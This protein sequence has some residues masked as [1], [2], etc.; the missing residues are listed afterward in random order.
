MSDL[1]YFNENIS[2]K[3]LSFQDIKELDIQ[4][5]LA[6]QAKKFDLPEGLISVSYT[7]LTLPTSPS[8]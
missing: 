5:P 7:H 1:Y 6:D 2:S 8:V 4:D 3:N